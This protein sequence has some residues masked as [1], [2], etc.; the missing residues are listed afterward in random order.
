M[1][2]VA[3]KIS[4]PQF[5]DLFRSQYA[6]L[7]AVANKYLE[8]LDAAEEVVQSVFVKFW[9]GKD[10]LEIKQSVKG[11]LF[12]AVKN[13][14]LNQLKHLKIKEEYKAHNQREIALE[15]SQFEG[16]MESSELADKIQESIEKLP[17][18]R[19]QIFMLS[20][21]EGLKYK[22]IAEKL[23]ISI[24]TVENQM[25]SALKFLKTQLSDYLVTLLIFIIYLNK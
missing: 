8:D 6:D 17:D 14:C 22:E 9:E 20:R 2:L 24:K 3:E 5:E 1:Q 18:A 15:E 7:C 11:Y 21:Y 25:G 19:K 23:N 16:D 10:S 13:N 12:T 4:L